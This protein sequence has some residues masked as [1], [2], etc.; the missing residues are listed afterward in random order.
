MADRYAIVSDDSGSKRLVTYPDKYIEEGSYVIISQPLI[1][2][3]K[4]YIKVKVEMKVNP[5]STETRKLIDELYDTSKLERIVGICLE[6]DEEK[7]NET[8]ES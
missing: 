4:A 3:Y 7:E 1:R 6:E 2:N 8:S 5:Y